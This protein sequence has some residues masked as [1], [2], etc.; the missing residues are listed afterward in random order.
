M[1]WKGRATII[2]AMAS[3]AVLV[4]TV[5]GPWFW[6]AEPDGDAMDGG[7]SGVLER[8]QPWVADEEPV[9]DE[10]AETPAVPEEQGRWIQLLDAQERPVESQVLFNAPGMW[11][12]VSRT[13]DRSGYLDLPATDTKMLDGEPLQMFEFVARAEGE[14]DASYGFWGLVS[15]PRE[16][17]AAGAATQI[18]LQEAYPLELEVVDASGEPVEGA[19]VRLA[20]DSVALVYLTYTTREDGQARFRG[21]PRGSYYL[22]LDAQGYARTTVNVHHS[23]RMSGALQ[24]TMD[25]GAGLR[26]PHSWRGPPVQ[27]I[28]ARGASPSAGSAPSPEGGRDGGDAAGEDPPEEPEDSVEHVNLEIY[29]ASDG[30]SGVNGAWIEVWAGGARIAQGISRGN[31][32]ESLQVPANTQLEVVATHSGWGEGSQVVGSVDDGDDV[33]VRLDN[34]V[35]SRTG[36]TDRI[37]G[38]DDIE[39]LLGIELVD[40]GERWL[41]E[42]SDRRGA[43]AQA[44]IE[45][46]DALLFVRREGG[47]HRVVVERR[48]E[49]VEVVVQ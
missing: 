36:A 31:A 17:I 46:G 43:T 1:G 40:D 24:V 33:T 18:R 47:G 42:L 22:T 45:R 8:F 28:A 29:V 25:D 2:G 41:I 11:P 3:I 26:L 20:R 10:V 12:F 49:L 44:G 35:L 14:D 23:E 38:I 7:S 37:T 48:R 30:G 27:E 16:K 5:F 34:D 21:I 9:P 32:A 4:M 6:G 15:G 39:A 13:T 19:Y